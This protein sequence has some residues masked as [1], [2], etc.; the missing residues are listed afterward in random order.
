M[1]SFPI[2]ASSALMLARILLVG[3]YS[4]GVFRLLVLVDREI[5]VIGYNRVLRDEEALFYAG[6][7]GFVVKRRIATS[8][9]A[10]LAMTGG[11]LIR[12]LAGAPSLSSRGRRSK[13]GFTVIID[14]KRRSAYLKGLRL[15]KMDREPLLTACYQA[16]E[17]YAKEIES[18]KLLEQHYYRLVRIGFF[19]GEHIPKREENNDL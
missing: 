7:S 10:L 17:R 8:E 3:G 15:W 2:S 6:A 18:Q 16:Q 9:F 13:A 11:H 4:T 19:K 1:S 5:I 12:P 14:D